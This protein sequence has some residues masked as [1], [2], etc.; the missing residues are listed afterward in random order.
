MRAGELILET[1]RR[2]G[3][4]ELGVL[5]TLGI[6]SVPVYRRPVIAVISSG[7]ELVDAGA[8]PG[9]GQ[10]RDSNR[11]AIAGTLQSLG[12]AVRHLPTL[13]DDRRRY[14]AV[15][16]EA[17]ATADAVVLTGGSSVGEHDITPGMVDALG[18]PGVLV[19]GLRVKP[20]KPTVLA[21]IDGKPVIGLPG[22]PT[23]ALM[24]LQAI[25]A[26]IVS[27]LAGLKREPVV[28]EAR[29]A[30]EYRK[31]PGW[32]WFVPARLE[33]TAGGLTA[34]LFQM[35]SSMVSLL[36]RASGFVTLDE[37]V[38]TLSVG[39]PVRVTRFI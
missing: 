2:I 23:S 11:W 15:L 32:T 6:T 10:I 34:H 9:P 14:E 20:G 3:G 35:R 28:V 17:I 37:S 27:A 36:A 29:V 7:D 18:A 30:A 22:N 31:R 13:P 38:E 4:A 33:H 16:R 24:I 5:A 25:G 8:M 26:P 1:G 21:S 39:E 12:V 19:H